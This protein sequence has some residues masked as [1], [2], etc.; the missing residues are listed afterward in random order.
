MRLKSAFRQGFRWG[1]IGE[2]WWVRND[3]SIARI[4]KT[5]SAKLFE[6]S[7]EVKRSGVTF[8]YEKTTFSC[9]RARG[10]DGDVPGRDQSQDWNRAAAAAAA[11][12]APAGDCDPGAGGHLSGAGLCRPTFLPATGGGAGPAHCIPAKLLARRPAALARTWGMGPR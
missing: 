7:E 9:D 6:E 2:V 10:W 8:A 5:K 4:F 12:A 1:E 3:G 11:I